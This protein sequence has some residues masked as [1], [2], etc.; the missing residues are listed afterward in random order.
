[1]VEQPS[2]QIKQ[3]LIEKKFIEKYINTFQKKLELPLI[4]IK[5]IFTQKNVKIY[6]ISRPWTIWE[7]EFG[8][9]GETEIQEKLLQAIA[10]YMKD[11]YRQLEEFHKNE[12]DF[13]WVTN[14]YDKDGMLSCYFIV[15]FKAAFRV[16]NDFLERE[17]EYVKHFG[18][19]FRDLL[20]RGPHKVTASFF[21][22]KLTFNCIF[23]PLPPQMLLFASQ[24]DKN[25][26]SISELARNTIESVHR[27]V[28]KNAK[29]TDRFFSN[30]SIAENR[31]LTLVVNDAN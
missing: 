15:F 26:A 29:D 2:M 28:S 1:M 6:E 3:N 27:E 9:P 8:Y 24:S 11:N 7:K 16:K 19:R 12:M 20:G 18:K 14:R 10:A 4:E 22:E 25:N 30:F 23:E 21:A 31:I 17:K 5:E 13:F